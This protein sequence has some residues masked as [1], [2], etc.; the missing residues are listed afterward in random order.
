VISD[1]SLP[2]VL[3]MMFFM[4]AQQI[5]QVERINTQMKLPTCT[6]MAHGT[7]RKD[8]VPQAVE[9]YTSLLI[10]RFIEAVQVATKG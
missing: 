5:V 2:D 7:A 6:L 1:P 10:D 8:K 9:E 3:V 4:D